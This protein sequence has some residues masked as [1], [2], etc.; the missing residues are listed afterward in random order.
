[1]FISMQGILLIIFKSSNQ[2]NLQKI[3]ENRQIQGVK[4]K[5]YQICKIGA[6]LSNEIMTNAEKQDQD[7][8]WLLNVIIP[9]NIGNNFCC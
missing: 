5:V 8:K 6:T 9:I 1:M 4:F 2:R 7:L 3:A